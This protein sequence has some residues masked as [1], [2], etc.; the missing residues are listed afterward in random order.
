M[1][2]LIA[3][4]EV[5]VVGTHVIQEQVHLKNLARA[6]IDEQHR[7]G[8]AQRLALKK[9]TRQP[10]QIAQQVDRSK[11]L[12]TQKVLQVEW[13]Q[14]WRHQKAKRDTCPPSACRT[15]PEQPQNN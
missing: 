15:L 3:T 6:I 1:L 5:I 12:R 4:G 13:G 14:M 2:A 8:V 9:C 11:R 7:F 10:P